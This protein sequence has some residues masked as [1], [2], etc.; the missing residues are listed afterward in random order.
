MALLLAIGGG[1]VDA[2]ILLGF[3]VLTAGQTGNTILLATALAQGRITSG[4]HSAVSI[5]GYI[6]GT[7]VGELILVARR[8]AASRLDPVGWT[9]VAELVPLGSL[10]IL[11]H[12]VGTNPDAGT[13]A[14]LVALGAMAMGVQSA[15]VLRLHTGPTTT[16][17]TGML[18]TFTTETIRWLHLVEAAGPVAP[19]EQDASGAS[20][21]SSDR[22]WVYG[23]TWLVY[24]G[25]ALASALLFL[26]VG[27]AALV[28]PIA[29]ILAV[30][31]AGARRP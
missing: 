15:A 12:L 22:P 29:A 2:A 23:M 19:T 30:V 6:S 20:V 14:V 26:W 5:V 18:T 31:V 27:T 24:A 8:D 13:G 3:G 10:L 1:S 28:L 16:Y 21:L 9:L 7:V 25:G 17:V 11:W 4:L